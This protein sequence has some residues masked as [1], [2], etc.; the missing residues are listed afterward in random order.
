[1]RASMALIRPAVHGVRTA[2]SS[3][4]RLLEAATA[5]RTIAIHSLPYTR[6][7]EQ[8]RPL[9]AVNYMM[10]FHIIEQSTAL[11][12]PPPFYSG[13]AASSVSLSRLI[14][15]LI[16]ENEGYQLLEWLVATARAVNNR[17]LKQSTQTARSVRVRRSAFNCSSSPCTPCTFRLVHG[18]FRNI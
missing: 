3:Y 9:Q 2:S 8:S 1:M 13:L 7:L 12:P 17:L 6:L 10:K 16:F 11:R 4:N 5:R 14:C 15:R 18:Y